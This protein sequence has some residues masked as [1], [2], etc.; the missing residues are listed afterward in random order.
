MPEGDTVFRAAERL[1]VF[2]VGREVTEFE[3]RVPGSATVDLRGETITSVVP[4]GKHLLHR[5][6]EHTLHSHLRM[7]GEWHTY[8]RGE[9]WRAQAH[10]ARA[11]VG[12]DDRQ[13][14]GFDL[15]GV[16]VVPTTDEHVFVDHLGPDPLAADWDPVEA[17][18]RVQA[19]PRPA[20]VAILDQR[21]VAGFGNEYAN[22]MLFVRGIDPHTPATDI[23]AAALIDTGTRMIRANLRRSRRVFTGVDKPGQQT[24]VFGREMRPCRRCGTTIRLDHLG[25]DATKLR[26]VFWCPRCQPAR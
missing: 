26:N 23:D 3:L 2:L 18:R 19:D 22:E 7:E 20:H 24:W 25:A 13:T 15:A 14:V 1:A 10:R 17:A 5:I 16:A 8:R 6:G 21:N 4:R 12:T 9:R 11:I